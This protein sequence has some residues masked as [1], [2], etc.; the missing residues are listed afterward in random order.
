MPPSLTRHKTARNFRS[1]GISV[2]PYR[3]PAAQCGLPGQTGWRDWAWDPPSRRALAVAAL[4][5]STLL[6]GTLILSLLEDGRFPL[7]D[8]LFEAS[9]AMGTV[10][11]SAVGTPN[12]SPA[13]RAI[14]LP[15]MFLGRVGP[16]T[17]AAAVA[18]R[19]GKSRSVSKYPEE[20]IMIG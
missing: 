11:V 10:G 5:L 18:K 8:L 14:L 15:M 17:L 4:F 3:C 16:L 13:G 9:S 7:E 6:T 19:Q 12:L 1:A 20:K 2:R